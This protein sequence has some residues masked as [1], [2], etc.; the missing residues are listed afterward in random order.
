MLPAAAQCVNAFAGDQAQSSNWFAHRAINTKL[1]PGSERT[2]CVCTAK[3]GYQS[4]QAY[5]YH[6]ASKEA[7]IAGAATAFNMSRVSLHASPLQ[8]MFSPCTL[9]SSDCTSEEVH[10][11]YMQPK[12]QACTTEAGQD[13]TD[14][15]LQLPPLARQACFQARLLLQHL[16]PAATSAQLPLHLLPQEPLPLTRTLIA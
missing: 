15:A 5:V 6:Q 14:L 2:G 1:T 10:Q 3:S 4:H 8:S 13:H 7:L 16:P 9:V 12:H 11:A